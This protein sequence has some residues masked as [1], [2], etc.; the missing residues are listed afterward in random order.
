M[1]SSS[2]GHKR[3]AVHIDNDKSER[4]KSAI[5]SMHRSD[6]ACRYLLHFLS[7]SV[8]GKRPK[9]CFQIWTGTGANGKGLTKNLAA[10]ALGEYYYEPSSA[11]FAHRSV[12]GS[13]LSSELAKLKGKRLCIS[14]E[15]EPG[16]QLRI[17]L[18]K[19]CTGHDLVQARDLY[20]S[21]SE[22]RCNANI[23]LCFNEVPG[24]DDPSGAIDRRLDMIHHPFKFVESPKQAHEKQIDTGLHEKFSSKEYGAC[25]LASLIINMYNEHGFNFQAPPEVKAAAKEFIAE[26][27]YIGQFIDEN[28]ERTENPDDKVMLKDIWDAHSGF[29]KQLGVRTSAI[30]SQK[31]RAKG[32][33]PSLLNGL[34]CLRRLKVK[35]A[36]TADEWQGRGEWQGR[37]EQQGRRER[38][39]EDHEDDLLDDSPLE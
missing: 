28:F 3:K 23:V 26:N 2:T 27:D 29:L 24:V 13:C 36:E 10:A 19:Q 30:L 31:L 20:K 14:S 16:D 8:V 32:L 1:V 33:T 37:R 15:A 38:R 5:Q 21:A 17:G 39:P 4:I 18:L 34:S 11:L 9:D 7:T 22:F 35:K 12:S 6:D 25:F